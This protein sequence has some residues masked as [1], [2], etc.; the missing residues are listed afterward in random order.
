MIWQDIVIT[1]GCFLLALS[2][3]PAILSSNK[4]PRFTC[5]GFVVILLSFA[6]AF[7]T[8][9]LWLSTGG[10]IAQAIAWLILLIQKRGNK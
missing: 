1:V 8:L 3:V 6:V 5:M 10:A 7:A 2:T 9:N 4:P